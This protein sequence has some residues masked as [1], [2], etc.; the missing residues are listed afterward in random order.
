MTTSDHDEVMESL[1]GSE[2]FT[3][4]LLGVNDI[5][6]ITDGFGTGLV[7][8]VFLVSFYRLSD[9]GFLQAYTASS[10]T[11]SILSFML[12]AAGLLPVELP[13]LIVA[14]SLGGL[15]YMYAQGRI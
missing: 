7:L 14:A 4:L 1:S 6:G 13:F 8:V 2:S 9:A 12:A 10:F 15:G 11:A 3:D 5:P